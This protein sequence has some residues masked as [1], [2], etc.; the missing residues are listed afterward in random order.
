MIKH[1][2]DL[3]ETRRAIHH[4]LR[5]WANATPRILETLA[6]FQILR[7]Q[8]FQ[9]LTI[10][11]KHNLVKKVIYEHLSELEIDRQAEA[12]L[13]RRRFLLGETTQEIALDLHLSEDQLNR[14]QREGLDSLAQI[15]LEH[16]Q[17]SRIEKMEEWLA[18]LQPPT[19]ERLYGVDTLRTKVKHL[20]LDPTGPAIMAL[21][22]LGGIGKTAIVDSVVRDLSHTPTFTRV[23]WLRAESIS[24]DAGGFEEDLVGSLAKRLL[25]PTD[26]ALQWPQALRQIFK[27]TPHLVVIDNLEE[28]GRELKWLYLLREFARPTK[29]VLTSRTLPAIFA[30]IEIV[31]VPELGL[32][33]STDFLLDYAASVGLE[34]YVTELS[35]QARS[36]YALTGGNPMALKLI[37]GLLHVWPLETALR[38]LQQGPGGDVERMYR[39]IFH[40]SWKTISANGRKVLQA[41]ALAG[42]EGAETEQLQALTDLSEVALRESLNELVTRSLLELRS[43]KGKPRYGVHRL[44]ETFVRNQLARSF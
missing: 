6:D 36:I 44:T 21:T 33:P 1:L 30:N 13:L 32:K 39:H 29:F 38:A 15:F 4:F 9:N 17:L 22:G 37:I 31:K 35:K 23:I 2:P 8:G 18:E 16:E 20:L 42:N 19:Y 12:D 25:Q 26:P 5:N 7:G 3:A 40:T 43:Q 27:N 11:Q 24:N 34:H 10:Q 28:E 14:Q 41:M